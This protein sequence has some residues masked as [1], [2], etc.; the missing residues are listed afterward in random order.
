MFQRHVYLSLVL[1]LHC[2]VAFAQSGSESIGGYAQLDP[3]DGAGSLA[4]F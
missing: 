2:A 3:V 4:S 1:C